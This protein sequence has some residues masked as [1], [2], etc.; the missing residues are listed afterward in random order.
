MA[1]NKDTYWDMKRKEV[2]DR[3]ARWVNGNRVNGDSKCPGCT[4]AL[5]PAVNFENRFRCWADD[6]PVTWVT[7]EYEVAD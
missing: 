2:A 4:N 1:T 7:V 3:A 5:T 6:C